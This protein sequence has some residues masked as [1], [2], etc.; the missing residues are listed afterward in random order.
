MEW[1]E[2]VGYGTEVEVAVKREFDAGL[3][4]ATTGKLCSP[5][6]E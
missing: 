1:L 4:H 2:L 6:S 5:S 3:R